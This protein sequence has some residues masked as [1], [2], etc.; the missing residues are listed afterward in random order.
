[1]KD[2]VCI[3]KVYTSIVRFY[4]RRRSAINSNILVEPDMPF[5]LV[6]LA[7][8]EIATGVV[9]IQF[10]ILLGEEMFS[11]SHSTRDLKGTLEQFFNPIQGE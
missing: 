3:G 4:A 2:F 11:Y 7:Y 6:D 10:E 9:V 1:M 5:L 8:H